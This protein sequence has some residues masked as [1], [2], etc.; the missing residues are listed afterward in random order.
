VEEGLG[1]VAA[2]NS[3]FLASEDLGEAFA[4]FLE[5]RKPVFKRR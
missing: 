3:A 1:Y 4:S 2:W 5:K